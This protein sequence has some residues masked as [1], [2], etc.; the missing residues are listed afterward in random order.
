MTKDCCFVLV[1]AAW[2]KFFFSREKKNGLPMNRILFHKVFPSLPKY[3]IALNS[4]TELVRNTKT[5]SLNIFQI[6]K[7]LLDLPERSTIFCRVGLQH[8][9]EIC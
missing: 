9:N 5:D 7:F 2:A 3:Q 6:L 8:A 4:S 1:F